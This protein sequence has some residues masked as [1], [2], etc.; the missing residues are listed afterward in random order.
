M[1]FDYER[2]RRE[3]R[4]VNEEYRQELGEEFVRLEKKLDGLGSRVGPTYF[5]GIEAL[6]ALVPNKQKMEKKYGK[7]IEYLR[8]YVPGM[9]SAIPFNL[10]MKYIEFKVLYLDL[11]QGMDPYAYRFYHVHEVRWESS[12]GN[13]SD[14][15]KV[16]TREHV[17]YRSDPAA[18]PFDSDVQGKVPRE[19]T[20]PRSLNYNA[21]HGKNID[22][23]SI[24][25]P[26]LSLKRPT[27]VCS[28]IADQ[29]Y[30][31]TTDGK[32]WYPIY[33]GEYEVEKGIRWRGSKKVFYFRKQGKPPHLNRYHFEV[34]YDIGLTAYWNKRVI[35][36][37]GISSDS[38]SKA[39]LAD[40]GGVLVSPGYKSGMVTDIFP[41][42]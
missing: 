34:E 2:F 15:A 19:F 11:V 40:F 39:E 41:E 32:S 12:T 16:A 36:M 33:G 31:Y 1:T 27:K 25:N 5:N 30:E 18:G 9:A 35:P 21:H 13:L 14:L 10:T 24:V 6:Y 17:T 4:E 37:I 8:R 29:V 7:A 23:H 26:A 3:L 22:D 20:Q 38:A 42:W 28:L